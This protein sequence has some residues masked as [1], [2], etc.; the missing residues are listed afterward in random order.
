M[1][2]QTFYPMNYHFFPFISSDRS[3]VSVEVT[4]DK[5]RSLE[6]KCTAVQV[7][8]DAL[9]EIKEEPELWTTH[10]EE[11][12]YCSSSSQ[13]HCVLSSPCV[14][15]YCEGED[16][17]QPLSHNPIS[18]M[19]DNKME[20]LQA[21]PN[22]V[23]PNHRVIYHESVKQTNTEHFLKVKSHCLSQSNFFYQCP[24]CG[25]RFVSKEKLK[26]HLKVHPERGPE[27]YSCYECGQ[28]IKRKSH[29]IE[30][31]RIHTGERPYL[32]SLCGQCFRFS[33][34]MKKHVCRLAS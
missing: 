25:N 1:N 7:Q 9:T 28:L 17:T 27:K 10:E 26:K 15:N 13:L 32:C 6:Q 19:E 30:H 5:Q 14:S 23:H 16:I 11:H 18:T 21:E 33:C 4:S 31:Y 2:T 22:A 24:I 8:E 34:Q 20:S 29:L 12:P 3:T